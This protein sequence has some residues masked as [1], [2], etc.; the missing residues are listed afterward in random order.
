MV[1]CATRGSA[2]CVL[3]APCPLSSG[4]HCLLSC[5]SRV[6]TVYCSTLSAR[7]VHCLVAFNAVHYLRSTTIPHLL[8]TATAVSAVYSLLVT[9]SPYSSSG[10]L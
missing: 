4:V 2:P 10:Y 1:H 3:E 5:I 7:A 9:V 8:L 6:S